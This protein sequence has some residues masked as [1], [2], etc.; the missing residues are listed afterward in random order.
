MHILLKLYNGQYCLC[1]VIFGEGSTDKDIYFK[2][3]DIHLKLQNVQQYKVNFKEN[4]T[5]SK[6]V[7]H[8]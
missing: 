8:I 4:T 6:N 1:V 3:L 2:Y 5:A 7:S